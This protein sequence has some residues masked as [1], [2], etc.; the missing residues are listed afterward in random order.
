MRE[1][2][3]IMTKW[4]LFSIEIFKLYYYAKA[5]SSTTG[6]APL[7]DYEEA[8]LEPSGD[9]LYSLFLNLF[10]EHLEQKTNG[11]NWK[12]QLKFFVVT[13]TPDNEFRW[14]E[15]GAR[16]SFTLK[17]E[18]RDSYKQS[19]LRLIKKNEYLTGKGLA[20]IPMAASIEY[21]L[22]RLILTPVPAVNGIAAVVILAITGIVPRPNIV[23]SK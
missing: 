5:A 9:D 20:D 2:L 13:W 21:K 8:A 16:G 4:E 1:I 3:I 19:I 10:F 22:S 6:A 14:N 18:D 7:P 11:A 23:E 17:A 12:V 15:I